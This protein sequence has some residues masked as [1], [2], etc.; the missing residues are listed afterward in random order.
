MH[1]RQGA[2]TGIF[3]A[4]VLAFA[5]VAAGCDDKKKSDGDATAS[6][7]DKK[8][9]GSSKRKPSSSSAGGT[10][11]APASGGGSATKRL[12]YP[13]SAD[14]LKSLLGEFTKPGAKA[15][16]VVAALKPDLADCEAAFEG[17]ASKSIHTLSEELLAKDGLS[18]KPEDAIEVKASG[19]AADFKA[20]TS[21]EPIERHCPGGYKRVGPVMKPGITFH[22]AKIGGTTLNLFAFVNGH[23]VIFPKAFRAIK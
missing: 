10:S 5:G 21:G 20:F 15:A 16:D 19:T 18:F 1:R 9:D 3:I 4:A 11:S 14:G 2:G 7:E 13:N 8:S 22:C 17:D 6:K 23:W 12:D